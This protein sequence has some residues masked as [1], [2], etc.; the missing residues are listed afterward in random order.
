MKSCNALSE[1]TVDTIP[2][3]VGHDFVLGCAMTQIIQCIHS[4]RVVPKMCVHLINEKTGRL[5]SISIV[6]DIQWNLTIK[7]T[8]GTS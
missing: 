3:G 7:T 2:V 4:I 6:I 1:S 5:H 8:Y